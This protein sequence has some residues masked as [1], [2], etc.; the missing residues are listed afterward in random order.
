M[1]RM[2]CYF[3][4]C[5]LVLGCIAG[6]VLDRPGETEPSSGTEAGQNGTGGT[7]LPSEPTLPD[8][9]LNM[10]PETP[11][12]LQILTGTNEIVYYTSE[13]NNHYGFYIY[14]REHLNVNS[15]EVNLPISH[16]YIVS[17]K[18]RSLK[19][20]QADAGE[21][22]RDDEESYSSNAFS[23]LLYLAYRGMDFARLG[24]MEA[25][26]KALYSQF[27]A[28]GYTD[29]WL[30][31]A[32][33]QEEYARYR[34]PH[35]TAKA[36]YEAYLGAQWEDYLA[37]TAEDLPQFYV[38][39]V[40]VAFSD[41]LIEKEESFTQMEIT[42]GDRVYHQ[43][44]GRIT[45][46]GQLEDPAPIDWHED[47]GGIDG[48]LGE[49]GC[50]R[51]YNGGVYCIDTLYRFTADRY[52][53][54]EKITFANPAQQ[55]DRVWLDIQPAAGPHTVT[56]WDMSEAFAVYPGDQ[57]TVYVAFRDA[58]MEDPGYQTE[59]YSFLEYTTDGQRYCKYAHCDIYTP[60]Q[61]YVWYALCVQ[62]L[63]LESYY[64]EY[65]YPRSE[66]WRFD[67]EEDPTPEASRK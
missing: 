47:W 32:L 45:L 35:E 6:C 40:N 42:I 17:V 16:D 58:G 51:P 55:I 44:I 28:G 20:I 14:S 25:K 53:L 2:I 19:G 63:D 12:D 37:L 49:G 15:I 67:P 29:L 34:E 7:L 64:L 8:V 27:E 48:I 9:D 66:P 38:Y 26:Y 39:Y 1:K 46:K 30:S 13:S 54:L 36:E 60:D 22:W 62:Q 59:V 41:K 21:V 24:E 57:V 3:V 5:A 61:H 10:Q 56:Q 43:Q 52:K 23:Y 11:W 33:T 18:E 50:I 31:G 4:L 65:F